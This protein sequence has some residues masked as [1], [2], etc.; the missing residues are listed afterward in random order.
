MNKRIMLSAVVFILLFSIG[1][2]LLSRECVWDGDCATSKCCDYVGCAPA[3]ILARI[4]ALFGAK[5]E[6][7]C[8]ML[9]AENATENQRLLDIGNRKSCSCENGKCTVK[10]AELLG[11]DRDE[12]GCIGSAG[13]SWCEAKQKCL[14]VWEEKCE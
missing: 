11:G 1:Y 4:G 8:G 14:R 3:P 7:V 6:A 13:Y 10:A 12:H 2:S 5:G 9:C